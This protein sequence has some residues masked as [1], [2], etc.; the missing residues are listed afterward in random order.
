MKKKNQTIGIYLSNQKIE[1]IYIKKNRENL[2]TFYLKI[3][4]LA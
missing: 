4:H 2:K 3:K 1:K